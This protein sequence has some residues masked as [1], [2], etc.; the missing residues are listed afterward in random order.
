MPSLIP[1]IS[2]TLLL[3]AACCAEEYYITRLAAAVVP[4]RM[5]TVPLPQAG[6]AELCHRGEG[7]VA[8]DT[9]LVRL[10]REELALAEAKLKHHQEKNSLAAEEALLQLRRKKEEI[11][12]ILSQP[13]EQLPFMEGRFKT[14]AD[15]RALD[16]LDKKIAAQKEEL[17]L[18]NE[19]LRQA[20]DKRRAESELRMPF[21]GRVQYHIDFGESKE[22]L[23]ASTGPL[24]TVVDD[25]QL[26][27][28]ITPG[29]AELVKLPPEKLKA[30]L[31]LGGG[32]YL[33][34]TWHHKRVEERN[35]RETLVYYFALS[36]QDKE[37]AWALIG[38]QTIAELHYTAT[39]GEQVQYILKLDLA[40]EAGERPYETWEELVA[41]LRPGWRIVFI[42]ETHICL[43]PEG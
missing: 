6:I 21:D 13:K 22:M 9:L 14:K 43:S 41:E 11:E 25:S 19:E 23:I 12:F 37:K 8:K 31:E 32:Q 4:Q 27:V 38:A 30:K 16:L 42:G 39:E 10:N 7:R 26:Y 2:T 20:F 3:C 36:E 24:F 35:N 29:E 33:Q 40:E 17:R 1:L 18:M 15:K 34:A 28:A 5:L